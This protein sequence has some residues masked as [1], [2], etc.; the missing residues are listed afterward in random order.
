MKLAAGKCCFHALQQQGL[1]DGN[2]EMYRRNANCG[3][4]NCKIQTS[5]RILWARV[6]SNN[7]SNT[8]SLT[9][10]EI[11][12]QR[13]FSTS[14]IARQFII[15]PITMS[16]YVE[17]EQ[18]SCFYSLWSS[19]LLPSSPIPGIQCTVHTIYLHLIKLFTENVFSSSVS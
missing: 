14:R 18:H 10:V 17:D 1:S 16:F 2:D 7:K 15:K 3:T 19:S 12:F 6:T 4:P 5:A 11:T 9:H 13:Y 8:S